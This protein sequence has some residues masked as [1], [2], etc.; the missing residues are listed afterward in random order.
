MVRRFRPDD[1]DGVAVALVDSSIAHVALEPERYTVLDAAT[2]ASTYRAGAQ[3]DRGIPPDEAATFVAELDGEVVGVV[4]IHLARPGGAHRRLDYGFVPELAVAERAR[5][6]G[7]GAALMAAAEAWA[8]ARGCAYLALDHN[9]RNDEA[10]R[11]YR[12]RLGFR[13]AGIILVKPLGPESAG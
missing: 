12:E 7:I 2:L 10:G 5:R 11:F 6:R 4:D 9:A 8:I 3:H 1:A 13:P